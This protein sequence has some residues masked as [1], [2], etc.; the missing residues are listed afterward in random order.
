M[1]FLAAPRPISCFCVPWRADRGGAGNTTEGWLDKNA[2][3]VR[4]SVGC[5]CRVFESRAH[6][7]AVRR[8]VRRTPKA[9][10]PHFLFHIGGHCHGW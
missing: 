1:S 9:L 2:H 6:I 5:S 10:N 7:A 3:I 4:R 8:N